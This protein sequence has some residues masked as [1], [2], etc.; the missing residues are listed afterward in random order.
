MRRL[1]RSMNKIIAIFLVLVLFGTGIVTP[2]MAYGQNNGA[3]RQYDKPENYIFWEM[4]TGFLAG[5]VAGKEIPDYL[6]RTVYCKDSQT[7]DQ[8]QKCRGLALVISRPILFSLMV[9]GGSTIGVYGMGGLHGVSGNIFALLIGTLTGTLAGTVVFSLWIKDQIDTLLL[10]ETVLQI[11][12]DPK[13]PE[14]IKR[15]LPYVVEFLRE[16]QKQLEEWTIVY[17]PAV[18]SALWGS[19]GYNVGATI[20]AKAR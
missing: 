2:L 7:E 10:P 17:F 14:Y 16:H 8:F 13:T 5:G 19:L 9:F 11:T 20:P 12:E 6:V 1:G 18:W 15:L 4:L 3:A